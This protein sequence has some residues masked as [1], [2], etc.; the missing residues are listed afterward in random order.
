MPLS[1]TTV[2]ADDY[3]LKYK[4]EQERSTFDV[5]LTMGEDLRLGVDAAKALTK[6]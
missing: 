4:F 5:D 6:R 1:T 2:V 3:L